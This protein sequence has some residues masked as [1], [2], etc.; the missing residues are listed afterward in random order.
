MAEPGP[1]LHSTRSSAGPRG[2]KV[3]DLMMM[4]AEHAAI[5]EIRDAGRI[6]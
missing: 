1:A 5:G 2:A 6:E 3:A 4:L